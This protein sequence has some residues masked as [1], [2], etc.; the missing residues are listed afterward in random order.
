MKKITR[1]QDAYP[2]TLKKLNKK[3]QNKFRWFSKPVNLIS[4]D[5]CWL[6]RKEG[7]I[8]IFHSAACKLFETMTNER[9][10]W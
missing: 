7:S 1:Y 4:N 8:Y 6:Q 3:I 2:S 5:I 10:Q 9:R